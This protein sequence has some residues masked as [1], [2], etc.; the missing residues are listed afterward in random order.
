MKERQWFFNLCIC[1]C[2]MCVCLRATKYMLKKN[3]PVSD[4]IQRGKMIACA[5]KWHLCLLAEKKESLKRRSRLFVYN[6]FRYYTIFSALSFRW[7]SILTVNWKHFAQLRKRMII[8]SNERES[9]KWS[10][11]LTEEMRF[12]LY[13]LIK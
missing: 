3:Y 2:V 11:I 6:P 1:M 5:N 8:C 7:A 9:L 10:I 13:W 12:S 4:A